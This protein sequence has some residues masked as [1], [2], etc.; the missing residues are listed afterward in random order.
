MEAISGRLRWVNSV[1]VGGVGPLG[2]N[3]SQGLGRRAGAKGKEGLGSWE[4]SW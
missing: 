4:G 2:R 1:G 3:L